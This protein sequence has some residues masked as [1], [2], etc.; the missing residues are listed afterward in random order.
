MARVGP[1]PRAKVVAGRQRRA[2]AT[3]L[4]KRL[5]DSWLVTI[6][7]CQHGMHLLD[8]EAPEGHAAVIE[9]EHVPLRLGI[10]GVLAVQAVR[11]LVQQ[12]VRALLLR[13]KQLLYRKAAL[14]AHQDK[15]TGAQDASCMVCRQP[16]ADAA[17][18][19]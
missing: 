15:D 2:Q 10:A 11:V 13:G 17:L 7:Q 19:S 14:H 1:C 12:P 6:G 3:Q 18:S 16:A 8:L 9:V 4:S 5:L